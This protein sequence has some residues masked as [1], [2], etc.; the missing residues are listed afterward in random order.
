MNGSEGLWRGISSI[1]NLSAP[2][3]GPPGRC[4]KSKSTS[5]GTP[6]RSS[7]Q[8]VHLYCYYSR[9]F[10]PRRPR[11]TTFF[12]SLLMVPGSHPASPGKSRLEH[13]C[14]TWRRSE[15]P[16]RLRK[17][18]VLGPGW[19]AELRPWRRSWTGQPIRPALLQSTKYAAQVS[20]RP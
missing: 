13:Y 14:S 1:F 20:A 19:P 5:L 10:P 9:R 15:V 12:P 18:P 11:P 6:P 2:T 16:R 3:F 17:T 8:V 7:Y 4:R